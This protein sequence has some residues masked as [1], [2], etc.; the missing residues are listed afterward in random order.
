MIL[1]MKKANWYPL[2]MLSYLLDSAHL[3]ELARDSG[4]V[5]FGIYSV[6]TDKESVMQLLCSLLE[7]SRKLRVRN[8]S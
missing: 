5:P 7:T 1:L 6:L 8:E 3:I 4:K 2:L